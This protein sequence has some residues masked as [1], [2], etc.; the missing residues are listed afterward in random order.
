MYMYNEFMLKFERQILV[1]RC[2]LSSWLWDR[3][4]ACKKFMGI[5]LGLE[6]TIEDRQLSFGWGELRGNHCG[7]RS[8]RAHW[9]RDIPAQT[10]EAGGEVNF[11]YMFSVWPLSRG[12]LKSIR[13]GLASERRRVVAAV[14]PI[15]CP[16]TT[17]RS[18][19]SKLLG[20]NRTH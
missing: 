13:C 18:V 1:L 19:K 4:T 5:H 11:C 7:F 8:H 15:K 16:I 17:P 20:T 2:G 10:F 14:T 3:N 12:L 9:R 6:S